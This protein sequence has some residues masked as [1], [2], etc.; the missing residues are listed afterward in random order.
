MYSGKACET[1]EEL[2]E[3]LQRLIR[4]PGPHKI[5]LCLDK[6][7]ACPEA[8]EFFVNCSGVGCTI[9]VR[10]IQICK[11]TG[12]IYVHVMNIVSV[13]VQ[14]IARR[15]RRMHFKQILPQWTGH[16]PWMSS[17]HLKT[18]DNKEAFCLHERFADKSYASLLDLGLVSEANQRGGCFAP[19]VVEGWGEEDTQSTLQ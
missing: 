4:Q 2:Y 12:S 16:Q 15:F 3:A 7:V 18:G 8:E 17:S 13:P 1:T 6:W 9:I 5:P 14:K 10:R 19:R 11:N